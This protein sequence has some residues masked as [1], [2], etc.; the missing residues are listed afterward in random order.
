MTI[1][2]LFEPLGHPRSQGFIDRVAA[3][4]AAADASHGFVARSIRNME[5]YER[6]WGELQIPKAFGDIGDP[7]RLPST[8]SIWDDLES[9]AAYAY[10]G[11]HGE[12]LAKRRDWFDQHTSPLYV[13]WWVE[14]TDRLE[15]DDATARLDHLNQHGPTPFAFDFKKPFDAEGNPY[16]LDRDRIKEKIAT[17]GATPS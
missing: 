4:F 11:T 10:H 7:L 14:E 3:V 1:G 16:S 13:A 17:N 15:P 8:L 6:S 5:T 2:V 9:V 12:A